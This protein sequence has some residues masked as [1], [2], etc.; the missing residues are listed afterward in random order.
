MIQISERWLQTAV[1]ITDPRQ[2]LICFP[3][4][5]GSASF[6]RGWGHHLP[7]TEVL[8]VRYP[9]RGERIDEPSCLDLR[10]LAR[11]IANAVTSLGDRPLTLFGHSMG[12][13][14]ALE[15]ARCLEERGVPLAHLF[16]SG[17]RN[18]PLPEPEE[19][20][21]EDGA[22]VSLRL[23]DLGGTD[24]E[25]VN[26]PLFQELVLPY[27]RDDSRMFHAHAHRPGPLLHCPVTTIVGDRDD[28]A[29]RRPWPELTGGDFQEQVVPGDHFYLIANPPYFLL[30]EFPVGRD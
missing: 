18:A 4:A 26:D 16:A 28:D 13:V 25:L 11:D 9:G 23:A 21:D 2:R 1:A 30:R 8:A 17:S 20:A 5:G 7:G 22:V 6:F 24:P 3:H 12:A 19:P 27:I 14:V 10:Q 29:D 15:T